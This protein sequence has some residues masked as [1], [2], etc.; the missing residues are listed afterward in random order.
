MKHQA[1]DA[2]SVRY[3]M[4]KPRNEGVDTQSPN[5]GVDQSLLTT[6]SF[7]ALLTPKALSTLAKDSISP[8]CAN[9]RKAGPTAAIIASNHTMSAQL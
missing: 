4:V 8:F 7:A 5:I 1:C 9:N 6:D 2:V 3:E